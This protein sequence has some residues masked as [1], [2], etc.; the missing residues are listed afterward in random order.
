MS[1]NDAPVCRICHGGS[2]LGALISPCRC[3][4]TMRLV[5]RECL[6]QWLAVKGNDKCEL[7]KATVPTIHMPKT[8]IEWMTDHSTRDQVECLALDIVTMCAV[9]FFTFTC[10]DN[11]L[12]FVQQPQLSEMLQFGSITVF[13]CGLLLCW[14]TFKI[15]YHYWVQRKWRR[16]HGSIRINVN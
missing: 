3:S 10:L 9:T 2:S 12:R 5:H 4:G 15:A 11:A 13:T 16:R 1:S 8:L 6:Q 7:C 14:M